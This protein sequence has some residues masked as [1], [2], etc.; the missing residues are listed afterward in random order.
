MT[1]KGLSA[2]ASQCAK[3]FKHT[4]SGSYATRA[5]YESSCKQFINFLDD[6]YKMKNLR[7]LQDK[8][9][10]AYIQYRQELG[11]SD[12]TL[13]GDLGAIRYMHD[14]VPNAKYELSTNE[15]LVKSYEVQ[16]GKTPAVKGDRAWT[17]KEYEDMRT[18]ADNLSQQEGYRGLTAK[19]VRDILPICRTMGLR[20]TEVVAMK[21]SQVEHALRTGIYEVKGEAKNGLHRSVRLSN[22]A[23][24]GLA[25]RIAQ[26]E[27][28]GLV[29]VREGEKVHQAVNRCE[30]FL[31][32]HR[33]LI[34]T[35]KGQ[36][37]R[38]Y[39]GKSNKLTYHGLRYGYVQDRVVEEMEKGF[40][41]EQAALIVTREVGH[42]RIDVIKIYMGGK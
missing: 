9:I 2:V 34:E 17:Q 7:N 3:L 32:R 35:S 12:K 18:L 10:V 29:F 41:Y 39:E 28:G 4:R 20:I 27:R 36:S 13:K 24:G 11:I 30:K 33:E 21:R 25:T 16:L 8:H 14:L 15:N 5:R 26:I 19:D 40:N 42:S 6:K 23:R 38:M 22:D 37:Q 1:T 31:G